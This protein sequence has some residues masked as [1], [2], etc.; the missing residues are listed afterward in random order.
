MTNPG[1]KH[2]Q[3]YAPQ[4]VVGC[5]SAAELMKGPVVADRVPGGYR[6][7]FFEEMALGPT[8]GIGENQAASRDGEDV[9]LQRINQ[10]LWNRHDPYT[11]VLGAEPEF[12]LW[13]N[14]K[15]AVLE[16]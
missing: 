11:A 4:H 5:P 14:R 15:G 13:P 12:G 16:V 6:L 2:W 9:G 7:A 8:A 3:R 1:L 10:H